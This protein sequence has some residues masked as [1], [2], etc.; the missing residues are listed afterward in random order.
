MTLLMTRYSD[1]SSLLEAIEALRARQ[2]AFEAEKAAQIAPGDAADCSRNLLH[3]V[4]MRQED[5]RPLQ[6]ALISRGLTSLGG[7]EGSAQ[8][9]LQALSRTLHTLAGK[10]APYY[11]APPADP[12][13]AAA[14]L[15]AR[16]ESLLGRPSG[17]RQARIMVTM[18]SE[19]A[20]APS[21]IRDLL[22]AGMDVMRI[23]CA[24]DGP[25]E[26]S[27]MAAHL[28][29]ATRQLGR[30]C[31]IY[32]DLGGPKLR[33]GDIEPAG[34]ILKLR[35]GR[36]SFGEVME[37]VRFWLAEPL[38]LENGHDFNGA[39]V[40]PV[41][42]ESLSR[43]AKAKTV[44]L[45][46]ARGSNRE[47]SIVGRADG[48]IEVECKQTLYLATGGTFDL[49][50]KNERKLS[51]GA[52]GSLPDLVLPIVLREGDRLV[53]TPEGELGRHAVLA[54]DGSVRQ[55]ARIPCTLPEVFGA[56]K[57]GQPIFFDDGK[58]GGVIE[59]CSAK[60]FT[61]RIVRAAASGAKLRPA[62][63]I[64]LP[65]TD[66]PISPL[67]AK[68]RADL[69]QVARFADVVGLSFVR[70]GSDVAELQHLLAQ[71]KREDCGI[72]AKIE[73]RPAFQNI[74]EILLAG[75]RCPSFGI[76]IAR[77]DLAVELGFERLSEAQEEI[78]WMCEAAHVP[79]IWATQILESLAKDGLPT[80]AEVTDAASAVNA[81][82]AMLNKGPHIT[83]AVR[84]LSG[85]LERAGEN[86][87]KKHNLLRKLSIAQIR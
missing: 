23:N 82:C 54:E 77:G 25:E 81:E 72:V 84:F 32:T 12:A 6:T 87:S 86:H 76:M 52:F 68:D 22:E 29:A 37:P 56:V 27:A 67:T 4:A 10:E 28:A 19:A 40:L 36:S 16:A 60:S 14:L 75:L 11:P 57:A 20:S 73:T 70:S 51:G 78:L 63:G 21:L 17:K 26:W 83:E 30:P 42:E 15:A 71:L 65:D 62:K 8:F 79:V 48:A 53:V 55:P 3:Y 43:S 58:I 39:P 74:V 49:C 46:D 34:Q 80:R 59:E 24:H 31:K 47:L 69:E 61:V 85:L 13:K 66:L 35:P 9:L 33:T 18:P 44:R 64:N 5:L 2:E 50:D 38:A 7:A 45:R 1:I 41:S